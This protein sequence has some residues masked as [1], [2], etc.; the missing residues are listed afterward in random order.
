MGQNEDPGAC[1]SGCC[2]TGERCPHTA[3][4]SMLA[5]R[6][7]CCQWPHSVA[8]VRATR[9]CIL[10]QALSWKHLSMHK[11][12]LPGI[13]AASPLGLGGTLC[14]KLPPTDLRPPNLQ[15]LPTFVWVKPILSGTSLPLLL[16]SCFHFN[17]YPR[18]KAQTD[19]NPPPGA[20]HPVDGVSG[21]FEG[22]EEKT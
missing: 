1:P 16:G 10:C 3:P 19:R 20:T 7:G 14:A 22:E 6:E 13:L 4:G 12:A 8:H 11:A 15:G 17:K 18:G 2:D 5:P 21:S 9:P